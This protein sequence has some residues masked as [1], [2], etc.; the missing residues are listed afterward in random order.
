MLE[1][2]STSITA[3][4]RLFEELAALSPILRPSRGEP[5]SSPTAATG[6]PAAAWQDCAVRLELAATTPNLTDGQR[7]KLTTR[8][9][10][11]RA[12]AAAAKRTQPVPASWSPPVEARGS[13]PSSELR[14]DVAC[15][16][17]G[18]WPCRCQSRRRA[19]TTTP[20][21]HFR[22]PPV[23]LAPVVMPVALDAKFAA[24]VTQQ[25]PCFGGDEVRS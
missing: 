6:A 9:R 21:P 16:A 24:A 17:C 19:A 12:N 8:A 25:L 14:A 22:T 10:V 15:A 13:T 20:L 5:S 18:D 3:A 7:A 1:T 4:L 11:A 23:R 2:P